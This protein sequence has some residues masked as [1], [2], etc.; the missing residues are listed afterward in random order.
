MYNKKLKNL[1]AA[2]K[3]H[4]GLYLVVY[5]ISSKDFTVL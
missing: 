3:P 2:E 5:Y 1:A 4:D